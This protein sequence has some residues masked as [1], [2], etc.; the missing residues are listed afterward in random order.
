VKEVNQRLA[1]EGNE[2]RL[3]TGIEVDILRDG[4]LD[5]PDK[6]LGELDVVVASIHQSF[7]QTEGELTQRLISA[8]RNPFVHM[9]GHL[10]G[11]LLLQREPYKVNQRAVI[12]AC[13]ASGTWIELNANPSAST[14]IGVYGPTP[15]AGES[16]A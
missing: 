16:N 15:K 4:T 10:T 13:A 6:S 1:D 5:L 3:L 8:A 7:N 12:D 11:R 14:W 2:F 9:L